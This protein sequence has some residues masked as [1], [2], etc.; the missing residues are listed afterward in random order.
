MKQFLHKSWLRLLSVVAVLTLSATNQAVAEE[1]VY[2][3]ITWNSTNNE[4]GIGSY[5]NSWT[6]TSDGFTCVMTNWNN[7]NNGWSYV[8]AGSKNSASTATIT[9]SSAIDVAITKVVVTVDAVSSNSSHKLEVATDK[10]FNTIVATAN[11]G[12]LS[13]GSVTYTITSPTANSYY[14]LTYEQSKSSNGSLQV[15]K[16]EFYY[17]NAGGSSSA[18]PTITTIDASDITNKDVYVSTTAGKLT[19]SVTADGTAIDGASVT[20]SS[21]NED[22]ATIAADGTVTLVAA[23]TTTITA[24]YAGVTNTYAASSDTYELIVDD[25]T[26]D[27]YVWAE[28][29]LAD[30]TSSDV[31]V[32]VRTK[33]ESHLALK[34]DGG[35]S[36]AP[37]TATVTLSDGKISSKVT[38]KMK[39]NISGD[40]TDGYVFYPDGSTTTWLYCTNTNNGVRVGTGENKTFIIK[41]DYL[42]NTGT[43][44]YIGVYNGEDWRCY[45]SINNNI[46]DQ[47]FAF[48]KRVDAAHATESVSVTSVGYGTYASDNALDF[49]D[50]SDIKV[51]Y[52]QLNGSTLTFRKITKVPAN[53][54][55]LLVTNGE[56]T[57]DVPVLTGDADK[58]SNNV[59]E[60]GTGE[61][62]TWK[63]DDQKYILFNGE[64]GIGF[65][66]A[67]NNR[68]ATNRAY[69]QVPADT[70]VKSF[71][72]NLDDDATNISSLKEKS[73]EA[74]IYNI[75][76]QR[77]S[78]M[79]RG[80]NIVNG[81]KVL[82]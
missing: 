4:K 48:Y 33:G 16:V 62:V 76:G 53:T 23:G 5:T 7:N 66:K 34:S 2:K 68:I 31:F 79:Q 32:I 71:V 29:S 67:N 51:F 78:K 69:I 47:T 30:L 25:S 77:I 63:E 45:T 17:D 60:R 57:T 82:F 40:A 19:A 70:N 14:R 37:G 27:S 72:I 24:S 46:K 12:T 15:S 21:S 56:V 58:V 74:A 3:T 43:S 44:R 52:A 9:T 8:K 10:D 1:V 73:G 26:P 38:D 18:V 20:W 54:G 55:V 64:D 36:S 65:Y 75:A 39:W 13:K 81:K 11:P 50:V 61:Q 59:F 80:I 42:Y 6:V 49:T 35:T 41:D 22:V 28:T